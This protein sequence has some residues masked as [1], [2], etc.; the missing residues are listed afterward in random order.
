[1]LAI[2][3]L[4]LV[5]EQSAR[6]RARGARA[7]LVVRAA[8][9]GAHEQ[10]RLLE[11]AHRASEMRAIHREDLIPVTVDVAHPA[12]D[13]RR[14]AVPRDADRIL[15]RG[16]TRLARGESARCSELDPGLPVAASGRRSEEIA[17]DGNADQRGPQHVQA[18]AEPEQ[19]SPARLRL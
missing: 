4:V 13:L 3:D 14:R 6:R 5:F 1:E 2:A 7:V 19:E 12:R 9:A 16:Q 11:P 8:V 17:D 18:E 10:A 15:V